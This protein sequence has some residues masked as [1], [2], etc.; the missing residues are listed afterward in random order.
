MA[1][2]SKR[3]I[4]S[5]LQPALICTAI[6]FGLSGCAMLGPDFQTPSSKVADEWLEP[7]EAGL[8]REE[9]DDAAWWKLFED[10]VLNT[11]VTT[12]YTQNLSLTAAGLRVLEARAILGIAT[13]NLYPQVQEGSADLTRVGLSRNM[14]NHSGGIDR[15]YTDASIGFDAAWELDVWGRFRRGIQAADA[16]YIGSVADYDDVLV[17]LTAEVARTYTLIRTLEQRIRTAEENVKIQSE[18]LRI[19]SVRY[20]NG[21]VTELDEQQAKALL[22]NTQAAIPALKISHR[23]ATNALCTLMGLAPTDLAGMLETGKIPTAPASVAVGIPANLLR[24]RPDIR[25][26]ELAAAAQCARIG[27]ARADLFPSFSL[28]GG[29]GLNAADTGRTDL[30]ELMESDSFGYSL[31]P[32][33]SWPIFNYGR[34]KN[35]VRAEDARFE[36]TI[37]IYRSAVLTAAREAEDSMVGFLRSREREGLLAQSVTA[38]RRAA[39]LSMTQYREGAVDYQRVLD[40]DRFLTDQQD[41]YT[42]VRGDIA[43]NLIALYK[44][45]GGGWQQRLGKGFVNDVIAEKM[46]QRTDWDGLL[47]EAPA[48]TRDEAPNKGTWRNPDW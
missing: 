42:A 7:A 2:T 5:V 9:P 47:E 36:Q 34:L 45:L 11:L 4:L 25:R 23:Q 6:L 19:A 35:R 21:V 48:V 24:R 38:A 28:I 29:L 8:S 44:A 1:R 3:G 16:E 20:N 43:L 27:I 41:L 26:A 39:E 31:G 46:V 14:A 17:S 40:S 32:S 30:S 37:A 13:G 10:P 33:V 15:F 18:S 22:R 12:A